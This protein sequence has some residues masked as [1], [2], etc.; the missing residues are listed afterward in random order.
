MGGVTGLAFAPLQRADPTHRV[1]GLR[2]AYLQL[3]RGFQSANI[4]LGLCFQI[5][6]WSS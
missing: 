1:R 6:A 3:T 5:H 2:Y 4:P